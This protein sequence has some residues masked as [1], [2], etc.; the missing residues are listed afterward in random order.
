MAELR[1][2][3]VFT[4]DTIIIIFGQFQKKKQYFFNIRYTDTGRTERKPAQK[5]NSTSKQHNRRAPIPSNSNNAM[6]FSRT[7]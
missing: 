4:V 5:N 1:G 7:S 2:I 3:K 6:A